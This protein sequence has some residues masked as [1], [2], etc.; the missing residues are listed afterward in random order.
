[1]KIA[2]GDNMDNI[3]NIDNVENIADIASVSETEK[4]D[5]KSW[6]LN[7]TWTVFQGLERIRVQS[8]DQPS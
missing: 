5:V 8:G 6:M 4:A 3:E 2:N 7:R 1:M